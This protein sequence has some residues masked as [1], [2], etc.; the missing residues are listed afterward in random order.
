M[1]FKYRISQIFR[2]SA[3][4]VLAGEWIFSYGLLPKSSKT[5]LV[6]GCFFFAPVSFSVVHYLAEIF[7]TAIVICLSEN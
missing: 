1:I 7:P 4:G 6:D 5:S 2:D 3:L